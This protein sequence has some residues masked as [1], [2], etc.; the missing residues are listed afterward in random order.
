MGNKKN[1]LKANRIGKPSELDVVT[2][3]TAP[4]EPCAPHRSMAPG[5]AGVA[6]STDLQVRPESQREAMMARKRRPS[7]SPHDDEQGS[8]EVQ[9]ATASTATHGV[10]VTQE[11]QSPI[12]DWKLP[13]PRPHPTR[14][15]TPKPDT[16]SKPA[17][18]ARA[19]SVTARSNSDDNAIRTQPTEIIRRPTESGSNPMLTMLTYNKRRRS[20]QPT[21]V[22]YDVRVE[23]AKRI[24]LLE[25][26]ENSIEERRRA[27]AAARLALID[28]NLDGADV[29]P[30][31]LENGRRQLATWRRLTMSDVNS[32]EFPVMSPSVLK[33]RLSRYYITRGLALN[34]TERR[35]FAVIDA[36]MKEGWTTIGM[37]E[38]TS[39]S[40]STY[41][42]SRAHIIREAK[43]TIKECIARLEKITFIKEVQIMRRSLTLSSTILNKIQHQ[44][45]TWKK[46]IGYIKDALLV[47]D[48][49]P[50]DTRGLKFHDQST[51][52]NGLWQEVCRLL[53]EN[54]IRASSKSTGK[55]RTLK[56]ANKLDK[57][58]REKIWDYAKSRDYA[59]VVAVMIVTGARPSELCKTDERPGVIVS[60]DDNDNLR[61]GIYSSKVEI[62]PTNLRRDKGQPVRY[63]TFRTDSDPALYLASLIRE[64]NN[65]ALTIWYETKAGR[66]ARA[67]SQV[68]ERLGE[69]ALNLR[70]SVRLTAYVLRH[71]VASDVKA[72][73]L[74]TVKDERK[75]LAD[76]RRVK[77]LIDI[78]NGRN[79]RLRSKETVCDIPQQP[80][81]QVASTFLGHAG[82]RTQSCYAS[83]SQSKSRGATLVNALGSRPIRGGQGPANGPRPNRFQPK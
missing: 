64:N 44:Y 5:R 50:P 11:S 48:R 20:T 54:K 70:Q 8:S 38:V 61:F 46:Y 29:R 18:K 15:T 68:L 80:E 57:N 10:P 21:R 66:P 83:G 26:L 17:D 2:N 72:G 4:Q 37:P 63:L 16:D 23:D 19:Q 58:W 39:A 59:A 40:K 31:V 75:A 81:L 71:A 43:Y 67:L 49:Y 1:D 35:Y 55:K 42:T 60:I 51:W 78:K 30:E 41:Y 12:P 28:P 82:D 76:E 77:R 9:S 69:K 47:L 45:N 52:R 27:L 56:K 36:A 33:N 25:K 73:L 74:D 14:K 13:R 79:P 34:K 32:L 62:D 53:K 22:V 65:N 6:E 3:G 24:E 7:R